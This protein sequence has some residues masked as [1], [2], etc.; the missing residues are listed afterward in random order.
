MWMHHLSKVTNRCTH[1][2]RQHAFRNQL[3]SIVSHNADTK[4]ALGFR[5]DDE[6]RQTVSPIKSQRSA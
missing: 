5:I 3:A 1:L 4:D 6:L 2:N